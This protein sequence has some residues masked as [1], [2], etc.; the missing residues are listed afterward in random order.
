MNNSN[1]FNLNIENSNGINPNDANSTNSNSFD[2]N[3]VKINKK[4][5]QFNIDLCVE[6]GWCTSYCRFGAL[7]FDTNYSFLFK[8]ENCKGCLLCLDACPRHALYIS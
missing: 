7:S 8:V 4:P 2:K 1:K 5:I 6:C 3:S